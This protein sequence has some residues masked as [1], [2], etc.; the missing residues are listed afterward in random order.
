MTKTQKPK[1]KRIGQSIG[2]KFDIETL[3]AILKRLDKFELINYVEL[4]AN[5]GQAFI[6][7]ELN[8]YVMREMKKILSDF[9]FKYTVHCTSFYN[10]RDIDN[11]ALNENLYKKSL[12]FS[13]EIGASV[14]VDHFSEKSRF[15]FVEKGYEESL[16]KMAEFA[17]D[18]GIMI[19]LE[20]IEIDYFQNTLDC[21][22]KIGH[23][24]LRMT[25]DFGHAFLTS[26]YFREDFLGSLKDAKPYLCH[27]HIHDNTG[28]YDV[29]R[30]SWTQKSLKE[31]LPLGK[32]DLHLPIGWGKIPF[33]EAFE[34]IG[35]G[36]EGIY[37]LENSIGVH[38]RF[39]PEMLDTLLS[40]I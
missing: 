40:V 34:I 36:Y 5:T 2:G 3:P 15:E 24:N 9:R 12:E 10:L 6:E 38:E 23:P 4:D 29:N 16:A 7:G 22:K 17:G 14:Y 30:L 19:G 32:G 33:K 31:R 1:S 26:K 25:F 11:T 20:H 35:D 27:L 18:L 8:P 21:I 39:L 28:N 37:M 13:K